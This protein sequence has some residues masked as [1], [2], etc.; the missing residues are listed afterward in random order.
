MN[1]ND[2]YEEEMQMQEFREMVREFFDE[3]RE[4][5][6]H[7]FYEKKRTMRMGMTMNLV[8]VYIVFLIVNEPYIICERGE[9]L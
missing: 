9:S 6:E 8:A 4:E 2:V 7:F 1:G 3:R 5:D